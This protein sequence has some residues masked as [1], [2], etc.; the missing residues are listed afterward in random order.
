MLELAVSK[1]IEDVEIEIFLL[2]S[3]VIK[4]DKL[5]ELDPETYQFFINL[6]E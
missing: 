2:R 3:S 6:S 4:V 1:F 5:P